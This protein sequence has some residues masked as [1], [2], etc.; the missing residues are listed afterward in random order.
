MLTS[1]SNI[2]LFL[3]KKCENVLQCKISLYFSNKNNSVFVKF[4]FEIFN[5][6]L[7]NDFANFEQLAPDCHKNNLTFEYLSNTYSSEST[8]CKYGVNI[9]SNNCKYCSSMLCAAI[10]PALSVLGLPCTAMTCLNL[11]VFAQP[12]TAIH[13]STIPS[14]ALSKHVLYFLA[15]PCLARPGPVLFKAAWDCNI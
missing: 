2:L 9:L 7:T 10:C 11:S 12:Y 5:A 8:T 6:T 1:F 3:L 13:S 14:S 4:T 15:L